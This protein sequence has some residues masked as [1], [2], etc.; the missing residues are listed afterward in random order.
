MTSM[1]LHHVVTTLAF[2]NKL[3][4][5]SDRG[6]MIK[7]RCLIKISPFQNVML[8][9]C[10][11]VSVVQQTRHCG[12]QQAR[13]CRQAGP[14]RSRWEACGG[15]GLAAP[16]LQLGSW[17]LG[18][19]PH[20]YSGEEGQGDE[21][22]RAWGEICWSL[23]PSVSC[24][25]STAGAFKYTHQASR[26]RV[27]APRCLIGLHTALAR[28]PCPVPYCYLRDACTWNYGS[29]GTWGMQPWHV[30]AARAGPTCGL[31]ADALGR[32]S[33]SGDGGSVWKA[34]WAPKAGPLQSLGQL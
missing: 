1:A 24:A 5:I 25:K 6:G 20:W 19:Q 9:W 27:A 22:C 30:P 4:C 3:Q 31:R 23:Q 13:W 18:S 33:P 10:L 15:G 32:S 12:E 8:P 21:P 7:L 29:G 34:P 14:A 17:L 16:P 2:G 26:S 28:C 11:K